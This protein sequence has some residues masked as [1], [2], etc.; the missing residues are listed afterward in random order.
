MRK[1]SSSIKRSEDCFQFC[2]V[3]RIYDFFACNQIIDHLLYNKHFI[4]MT[5][6]GTL[7]L[8]VYLTLQIG[9]LSLPPNSPKQLWHHY[10]LN[11][12]CTVA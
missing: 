4:K 8:W 9:S 3:L 12:V 2:G 6:S 1:Y 5:F 10:E 11:E 7:K